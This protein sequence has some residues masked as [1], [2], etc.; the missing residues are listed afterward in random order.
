MATTTKVVKSAGKKS[1]PTRHRPT[2]R[3]D[4]NRL[5]RRA[6][7]ELRDE[8]GPPKRKDVDRRKKKSLAYRASRKIGSKHKI[9][10]PLTYVGV[11]LVV[12]AWKGTKWTSIGV[13]K[14]GKWSGTRVASKVRTDMHRR[15]WVPEATRPKNAPR[16]TRY[17][18]LTCACGKSCSS[19]EALNR[20][21]VEKHRG[22]TRNFATKRPKIQRGHTRRTN[23][24]VI[25][26]PA[27]TGGGRH[28]ARH[29]LPSFQRVDAIIAAHRE[30]ITKIGE[31]IMAADSAAA[32][33]RRA[34]KQFAES[35]S[36]QTLRDLTEQCIG[37]ER[38]SASISDAIRDW[39]RMLTRQADPGDRR[40]ANIDP[41]LVRP[42]TRAAREH[43]EAMGRE[44]TRFIAAFQE[45][46]RPE[47]AA[48]RKKTT[49]NMDLSKT[50]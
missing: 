5:Q 1:A 18:Q 28:R 20:H 35:P 2:P 38:A 23:G 17:T 26:R 36:P 3:R 22:E 11:G 15:K 48:A 14:A 21:L 50:G 49:P 33:F 43:V 39:E 19:V 8:S 47:I 16:F 31:T 9:L 12:G 42:F 40:G 7:Q 27:G 32:A 13:G 6:E 45:F 4:L 46:Y 41:A 25:V 29:H 30:Q 37:M 34:A 44:F 24:K 10:R